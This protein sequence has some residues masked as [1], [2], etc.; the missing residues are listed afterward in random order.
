[1]PRIDLD[2]PLLPEI[3]EREIQSAQHSVNPEDESSRGPVPLVVL[4]RPRDVY[5]Q[6][7]STLH[8]PRFREDAKGMS[9]C[10]CL[11]LGVL[12]GVLGSALWWHREII[13][14]GLPA[15]L[16]KVQESNPEPEGYMV[17]PKLDLKDAVI[18]AAKYWGRV[19]YGQS[20]RVLTAAVHAG[21]G[22]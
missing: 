4:E 19:G 9:G 11:V 8:N 2:N 6:R 22:C 1:M 15:V 21:G 7:R 5:R 20:F 12:V 3:P 18:P 14:A 13:I 16:S 10:C 17:A